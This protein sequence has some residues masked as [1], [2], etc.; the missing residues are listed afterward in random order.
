MPVDCSASVVLSV[1]RPAH[2]ERRMSWRIF[3]TNYSAFRLKARCRRIA[4]H[5][6]VAWNPPGRCACGQL[7]QQQN[8]ASS[9]QEEIRHGGSRDPRGRSSQRFTAYFLS[10]VALSSGTS[11]QRR[12]LD[13]Q[14]RKRCSSWRINLGSSWLALL[15]ERFVSLQARSVHRAGSDAK[16]AGSVAV[17]VCCHSRSSTGPGGSLHGA[18]SARSRAFWTRPQMV[19]VRLASAISPC[20]GLSSAWHL[21]WMTELIRLQKRL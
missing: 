5:R 3:G 13:C 7:Q 16:P 11:S 19:P 14:V 1:S 2:D 12:K 18:A 20:V 4:N 21:S 17:S 9:F 6:A 8:G 10:G 15:S